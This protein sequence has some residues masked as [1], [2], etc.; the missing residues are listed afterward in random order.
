MASP[1]PRRPLGLLLRLLLPLLLLAS[2]LRV[3]GGQDPATGPSAPASPSGGLP[4]D[5][6]TTPGTLTATPGTLT[7]TPGTLTATPGTLTATPGTLTAT[8]R[9]SR[10]PGSSGPAID[11]NLLAFSPDCGRVFEKILG[12]Q[13]AKEGKWPWQVSLR[14]RNRHVC[15][16]TL[17]TQNWVLSAAHCILSRS[18]YSVKIGGLS[19]Y[20][21]ATSLVIPIR[22]VIVHP[23]FSMMGII[24][25]DLALLQ[26]VRSVN[27]TA[28]THPVCIPMEALRVEAGT[29]CWVTG[30]GRREESGDS[31]VSPVLQEVDQYIIYYERCNRM[32]QQALFT[33]RNKVVKGM[34][35]GYKE[36]GKDACKGDSG[37][38]LLCELNLTWVQVGIVSWG[39]GCGRRE[40]PGV[41]TDVALY[42][43][44]LV[45][46]VN[47]AISL[48][49]GGLLLLPL[50]LAL[51]LG[52]LLSL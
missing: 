49:P 20:E 24:Q 52:T 50:C 45:D 18:Y 33:E 34:V 40:V 11:P 7:A 12:G 42:S 28:S 15:G 5:P 35:C 3:A 23:K 51:P 21:E 36:E 1:G 9:S 31:L 47:Q 30:W 32:I 19:V 8:P 39:V 25:H 16:G 4:A 37:G 13:D 14:I 6:G 41:Y 29:Q 44:W 38:P 2:R 43:K 46:V 10:A 48:Y 22:R 27:F 17:I 26:L